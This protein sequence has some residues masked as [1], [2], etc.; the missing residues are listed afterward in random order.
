MTWRAA[1]TVIVV[2]VALIFGSHVVGAQ[3][4]KEQAAF[5]KSAIEHVI[6]YRFK[7]SFIVKDTQE[8]I[9]FDYVAACAA[10]ETTY[11]DGDRSMDT[12]GLNPLTFIKATSAGHAIQVA[13]PSA[14]DH[15][16]AD[17]D[18]P[19]D[20][21]PFAV[22][23]DD[24]ADMRFG[25]GYASQDAYDGPKALMS[26]EGATIVAT[27]YADWK[28][29]RA[30]AEEE[31]K[32]VGEIRSPWGYSREDQGKGGIAQYCLG[33]TRVPIAERAR[34][35]VRQEWERLGKPEFWLNPNH[36]EGAPE[37]QS[38]FVTAPIPRTRGGGIGRISDYAWMRD[39]L[40]RKEH[41][42][43]IVPNEIYPVLPSAMVAAPTA[44]LAH[45]VFPW[46]LVIAME[47]KGLI[48]C[49]SPKSP[50]DTLLSDYFKA[51]TEATQQNKVYEKGPFRFLVNDLI[52]MSNSGNGLP[53]GQVLERD[54]YLLTSYTQS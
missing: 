38:G 14:C 20:L 2:G 51:V 31:F 52:I 37:I 7:A 32:P 34:A 8:H 33:Y 11:K 29:W 46:K 18:I 3:W 42:P 10:V 13:T 4:A 36:Q 54:E 12:L 22:F 43:P 17:G 44:D 30:K 26:F 48:S 39:K 25:W 19:P 5:R 27:T 45:A 40:A 35:A 28:A 15:E 41:Y 49:G 24:V 53:P 6:Y 9:D 21:F 16:I 23:Y 47:W 1:V 50:F